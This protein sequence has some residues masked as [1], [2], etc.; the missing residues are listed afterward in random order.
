MFVITQVRNWNL[1]S[2]WKKSAGL[3]TVG[4]L[5]REI[6]MTTLKREFLFVWT[7][8]YNIFFITPFHFWLDPTNQLSST[9]LSG[10]TKY[11]VESYV[12][13]SKLF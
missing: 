4:I 1:I 12:Q 3:K 8:Q 11:V 2:L 10:W 13:G 9:Y 6:A 7:A 5:V